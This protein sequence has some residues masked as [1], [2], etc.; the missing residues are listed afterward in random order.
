MEEPSRTI[1]KASEIKPAMTRM[2]IAT[3]AQTFFMPDGWKK[4][5]STIA[6]LSRLH[7]DDADA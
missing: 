3:W 1:R 5:S 4:L 7:P 6:K 2:P